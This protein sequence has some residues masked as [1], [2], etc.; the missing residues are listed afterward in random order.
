MAID[1]ISGPNIPASGGI[2]EKGKTGQDDA[3]SN[4]KQGD[5]LEAKILE[6]LSDT[7]AIV[8]IGG[9]AITAKTPFPFSGMEGQSVSLK[10]LG[11][12]P[13]GELILKLEAQS[14]GDQSADQSSAI[15]ELLNSLEAGG[16]TE[17]LLGKLENMLLSS[18]ASEM[19]PAQKSVLGDLLVR[20]IKSD[21][22]FTAG[23]N[24]LL[25][26]MALEN[27]GE[28][29]EAAP[30]VNQAIANQETVN[31]EAGAPLPGAAFPDMAGLTGAALEGALLESGVLLEAKLLAL[32]KGGASAKE[33]GD[34]E[35][36]FKALLLK[37][38]FQQ[39]LSA[40]GPE[41]GGNRHGIELAGSLLKDLRAF[42]FLSGLTG[43]L[44]SF[45]PVRWEGLKDGQAAFKSGEAGASCLINLDLDALGKLNVSV[46]TRNAGFYVTLR[47]ENP[48]FRDAL[49]QEAGTLKDIFL[50]KGL[51]LKM[52]NVT[53]YEESPRNHLEFPG[54]AERLINI[55]L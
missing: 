31:Q 6:V 40:G 27:P 34:L 42:Q 29:H 11:R 49:A 36:D 5:F 26:M 15:A 21:A 53:D 2:G 22:A 39:A 54:V 13:A 44:Y 14:A 20:F 45:L 48:S 19:K 52:V 12:A 37:F 55:R 46:F 18:G 30:A 10:V 50:E 17:A 28:A 3:L 32:A 8:D 33:A 9:R 23:L 43:S 24:D 4:F 47:V 41:R 16:P 7:N 51:A 35:K 38:H 1:G 25:S